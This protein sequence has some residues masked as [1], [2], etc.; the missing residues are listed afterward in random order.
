MSR[1]RLLSILAVTALLSP[2]AA[3]QSFVNFETPHVHPLDLTPDGTRLLAVNT[4]DDRLEVFDVSGAGVTQLGTVQVG[5]D[6]VSVRARSNGEVWVVNQISDSVSV[7]DLATMRVR[8]T[9][10]TD[11]EPADVAFA[12][13]PQRAFVSCSQASTVLVFDPADLAAAPVTVPI[14]AEDP[15]ALAVSPDG[16]RVYVAVFDS[17]NGSTVLGGGGQQGGNLA[18]P[19]NVVNDAAGPYG[20]VNPP[21]NSGGSFSPPQ[22]PN[23]ATAPKG[24]L[25]I[26]KDAGGQW[27]D[28]NNGNWTS[29]VSGAQAAKSGRPVGWDLP[30]RD[31]AVIDA[32]TLGVTWVNRL[33]NINM[34]IAV[35]PADG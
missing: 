9:L 16:T 28:D 24:S 7:V 31:V 5:L 19:P 23:N 18:F 10:D 27:M 15:R 2:A 1:P 22:N 34:A 21:P 29:L 35:N 3:S 26:K 33:M 20:G 14:D 6:P 13:T 8:A 4:P 25:I 12:G 30:D 32:A 11:D 17:G